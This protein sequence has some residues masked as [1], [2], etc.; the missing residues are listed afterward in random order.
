M[1]TKP[2]D[3]KTISLVGTNM[4]EASAGTGKT[5]S[6][7]I[8]CLRLL[9][10]NHLKLEEVL[11]VTFTKA[12]VG[13]LELRIRSFIKQA[14]GIFY[15]SPTND[16]L[17]HDLVQEGIQTYGLEVMRS[18]LDHLVQDLDV[19]SI[20][21]IHSFCQNT[22]L[23][24]AFETGMLFQ[25]Q[26]QNDV[27]EPLDDHL[28]RFFIDHIIQQED[29]LLLHIFNSDFIDSYI[30]K[31]RADKTFINLEGRYSDIYERLEQVLVALKEDCFKRQW[32]TYDDLI[33]GVF[34]ARNSMMLQEKCATQYKAV[35]VDEFQDT[36]R[37]Q[38]AIF[39]T[40]FAGRSILFY[41]GDP[42]QSIYSFRQADIQTYL[43]ARRKVDNLYEMNV[44]FRSTSALI[45]ACN[46]FFDEIAYDSKHDNGKG[47]FHNTSHDAVE[48][49]NYV[50]VEAG[51]KTTVNGA[52]VSVSGT[53]VKPLT[54]FSGFGTKDEIE[55][56]VVQQILDLLHHG[57]LKGH[58]IRA[59][60]I[61]LLVRNKDDGRKLKK[62]L[63]KKRIPVVFSEDEQLAQ[64][65]AFTEIR[66]V[67]EAIL[68][69]SY[70]SILKVLLT[71]MTHFK[72]SD[73]PYLNI[74]EHVQRFIEFK[75]KATNFGVYDGLYAF[76]DAYDVEGALDNNRLYS[77]VVQLV[78]VL[79]NKQRWNSWNTT[80]LIQSMMDT[81]AYTGEDYLVRME[82]DQSA[83]QIKTIHGS[84]GLQFPIVMVP[85][86]DWTLRA[87]NSNQFVEYRNDLGHY[88]FESL[89]SENVAFYKEQ[90]EQEN[91]RLLYVACTRAEYQ[92]YL[93]KTKVKTST[94]SSFASHLQDS[95]VVEKLIVALDDLKES[96]FY[97]GVKT[98]FKPSVLSVPE[99]CLSD[100]N[101]RKMSFTFLSEHQYIPSKMPVL[102]SESDYDQFVFHT[103]TKGSDTGN[104]LHDILE[105][106]DFTNATLWEKQ[107]MRSIRK[108]APG[109]DA[110][111]ADGLLQM[112]THIT[113]VPLTLGESTFRLSSISNEQK[114]NE[115]EFHIPVEELSAHNINELLH[116]DL[117]FKLKSGVSYAGILNGLV[118][119]FFEYQGMYY[120]LDW[121]SNHLGY[122]TAAYSGT[123]M[124]Q[125]MQVNNYHLQH[126]I[127]RFAMVKY[128][129][130]KLPDFD[131]KKHFGGVIYLFLRGIRSDS[132]SGIYTYIN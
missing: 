57:N 127:Y 63:A 97:K 106:I 111:Y 26:M 125:A 45:Q 56:F 118:D 67:L 30:G 14:H 9:L 34:H 131:K 112:L 36:D 117:N 48:Q 78:E 40:L 39:D 15:N 47:V 116:T 65:A 79:H 107:I 31:R 71:P 84:K 11:M 53:E 77:N 96:S 110:E 5:Y 130:S 32:L 4:V 109:K 60:D 6:I 8:L 95:G 94:L 64:T 126:Q 85:Y 120:I 61:A 101:W 90:T 38:F 70:G 132:T 49:I 13:E 28:N 16:Q 24:H 124:E 89:T 2:F 50:P 128:L 59:Q 55:P 52:A 113:S 105:N 44:N 82:T 129:K 51:K 58:S 75:E 10:E 7:A 18:R 66:Y 102:K 54:L 33:Q 22:L 19:T 76:I 93:Y 69:P 121:K 100:T 74:N 122:T 27:S 3:V 83:L 87:P 1:K 37:M 99:I 62:A 103:L 91:R 80:Q 123:A 43:N 72:V 86:T 25:T 46:Q 42:K 98:S 115:L 114:K 108:F 12:A 35:F 17:I 88:V 21:T 29:D 73:I 68:Q 41:I 81:T 104:L 23:T 20:F 92:L 119:L